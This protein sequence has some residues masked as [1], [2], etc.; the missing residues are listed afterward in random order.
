MPR[1]QARKRKRFPPP[2]IVSFRCPD[3]PDIFP[4]PCGKA[5]RVILGANQAAVMACETET[6]LRPILECKL[7]ITYSQLEPYAA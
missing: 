5:N 2:V 3:M 1:C 4:S 6:T 7:L